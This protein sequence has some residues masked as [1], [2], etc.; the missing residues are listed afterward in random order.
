MARNKVQVS[1]F[2]IDGQVPP[3][4][5]VA[6]K[7]MLRGGRSWS[8]GVHVFDT[9]E[10]IAELGEADAVAAMLDTI[11]LYPDDFEIKTVADAEAQQPQT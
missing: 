6:K 3:F 1:K 10:K 5:I 4:A 11:A 9:A 8:A 7:S 2:L